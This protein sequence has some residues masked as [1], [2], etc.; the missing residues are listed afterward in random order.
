MDGGFQKL[1]ALLGEEELAGGL[2]VDATQD[3]LEQGI[4][5]M[6]TLQQQYGRAQETGK[7]VLAS[8]P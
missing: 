7:C 2:S 5:L 8:P 3:L 6:K 1:E 4:A